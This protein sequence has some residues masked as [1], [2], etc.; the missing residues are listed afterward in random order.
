MLKSQL[1]YMTN[2]PALSSYIMC[3]EAYSLVVGWLEFEP[4]GFDP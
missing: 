2:Y 1:H 3:T 4:R